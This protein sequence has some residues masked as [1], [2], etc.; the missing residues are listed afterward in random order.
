MDVPM[1][2]DPERALALTYAGARR[3]A[4]AALLALDQTLADVVRTTSQPAIGQIR[5]AWWDDALRKLDD[6]PPPA[7]PT[8]QSLASFVLPAGVPGARL[9]EMVEGWDVLIE[10]ETL[11]D[12]A[13]GRFA[14]RRGGRL[15]AAAAAMLGGNVER[16]DRA[17]QG[18]ALADLMQHLEDDDARVRTGTMARRLLA[19]PL[20]GVA[21]PL[22]LLAL[23]ARL[24]VASVPMGGPKR[25][26]RLAWFGLSGR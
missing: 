26:A 9:A 15:F 23:S 1:D 6:A 14:E 17:G 3:D 21:R 18:W 8:L 11:D 20:A 24:D 5:L 7:E 25:A 12:D 13:L 16:A 19:G 22:G 10:E 2:T 4:L